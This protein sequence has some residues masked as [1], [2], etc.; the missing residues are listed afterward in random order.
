MSPAVVSETARGP[1]DSRQIWNAIQTCSRR[2][3]GT[4]RFLACSR[5]CYSAS[6]F[7]D[8]R[9]QWPGP[10]RDGVWRETG[11]LD[12]FPAGGPKF[13]WRA[14]IG[15]GYSG[16][17][18]AGDKVFVTDR[19]LGEGSRNPA[20]PFSRSLVAGSERALPR[21]LNRQDTVDASIFLPVQT[22]LRRRSADY[23][24]GFGRL[25]VLTR[26]DG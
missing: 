14:T 18:V 20:S 9:P 24:G 5:A 8:D 4:C 22:E 13:R 19:V 16:L 1:A 23:P 6:V 25:R 21:F 15:A 2:G 10:K 7:A 17:A 11:I 3:R 12:A 26:S